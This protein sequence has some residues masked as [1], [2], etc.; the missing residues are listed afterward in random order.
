MIS[1]FSIVWNCI[2]KITKVFSNEITDRF[3]AIEIPDKTVYC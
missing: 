2:I 3:N 1:I